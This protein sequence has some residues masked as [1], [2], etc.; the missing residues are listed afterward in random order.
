VTAVRYAR[1]VV[2]AWMSALTGGAIVGMPAAAK[3]KPKP[4]PTPNPTP[5]VDVY[6]D[7]Y[8]DTY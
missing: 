5:S 3:P 2:L 7:V 1:R 4:T 6:S 8:S